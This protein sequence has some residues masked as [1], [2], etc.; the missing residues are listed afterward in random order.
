MNDVGHD[1]PES[2]AMVGFPPAYCRV[3][4]ARVHGDDACV[5]LNTGSPGQPYLYEVHCLRRN[6]RWFDNGSGNGPCWHQIGDD[7]ELGTLTVWDDAPEGAS[8]LRAEFEGVIVDEPVRDGAY[9]FVWWRVPCPEDEWPRLVAM[10]TPSGWNEIDE[11][12]LFFRDRL[13]GETL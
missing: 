6:G 5:L 12:E 11:F 7:P 8:A 10:L 3:V 9:L 2:A 4:A 1:S 13:P